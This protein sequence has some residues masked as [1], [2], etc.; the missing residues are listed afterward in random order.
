MK[1]RSLTTVI[2]AAG[3]TAATA[4]L[5]DAARRIACVMQAHE[6]RLCRWRTEDLYRLDRWRIEDRADLAAAHALARELEAAGHERAV[7]RDRRALDYREQLERER[8]AEWTAELERDTE[9]RVAA[10]R[11]SATGTE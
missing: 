11:A 5:V 6:D 3:A 7:E 2:A 10:A 9:R 4:L 8:Q 1:I